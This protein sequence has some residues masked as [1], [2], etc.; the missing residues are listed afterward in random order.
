M[1]DLNL[2][3]YKLQ[4]NNSVVII[5]VSMNIENLLGVIIE[6]KCKIVNNLLII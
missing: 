4:R 1:I 6:N 5:T 3:K 2:I